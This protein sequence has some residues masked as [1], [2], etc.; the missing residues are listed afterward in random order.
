[1][2]KLLREI[3][4]VRDAHH[5]V[6]VLIRSTAVMCGAVGAWVR[7]ETKKKAS[8][9]APKKPV[10]KGQKPAEGEAEEKQQAEKGETLGRALAV[11]FVGYLVVYFCA[12]RPWTWAVGGAAW[13]VG[14]CIIAARRG[15]F[16]EVPEQAADEEKEDTE[17]EDTTQNDHETLGEGHL[18]TAAADAERKAAFLWQYVEYAVA[19]AVHPGHTDDRARGKGVR[20]E[21]L[22]ADLQAEGNLPGWDTARFRSLLEGTGIP[23]RPQMYF[24]V[25]GKKA[26]CPGVHVEDLA[27]ALG[28]APRL[29]AHLVP[30][31]TPTGPSLSLVQTGQDE[32]VA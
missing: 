23:V 2:G 25:R 5:L 12:P 28:R 3:N 13:F 9:K 32:E 15:D 26:N 31:L 4:V 7:C 8:K 6:P 17:D 19:A 1:M 21:D 14:C 27:G 24:K 11:T 29:P 18:E 20:V 30:D 22:L 16:A 10:K